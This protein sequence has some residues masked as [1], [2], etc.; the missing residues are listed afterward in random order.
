MTLAK[1]INILIDE[2]ERAQN[3]EHIH[4]P[5]AWAL[6]IRSGRKLTE[7]PWQIATKNNIGGKHYEIQ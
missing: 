4:N 1:A 5:V 6:C 3:M 7:K 2:Y